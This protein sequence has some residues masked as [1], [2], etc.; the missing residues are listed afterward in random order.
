MNKLL[1]MTYRHSPPETI[2]EFHL[3][4][5]QMRLRISQDDVCLYKAKY[6]HLVGSKNMKSEDF[7]S[8][9]YNA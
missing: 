5:K 3:E 1:L 9:H 8:R 4:V 7:I 6:L 2:V